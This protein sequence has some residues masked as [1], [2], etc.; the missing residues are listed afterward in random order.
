MENAT[1]A[2]FR[3]CYLRSIIKEPPSGEAGPEG[4]FE[5]EECG[6]WMNGDFIMEH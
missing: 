4:N 5:L 6:F 3:D 1:H 2:E